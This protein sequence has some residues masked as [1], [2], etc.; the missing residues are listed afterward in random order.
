MVH[1]R[2]CGRNPAVVDCGCHRGPSGWVGH[3]VG[4][5][6]SHCRICRCKRSSIATWSCQAHG[7]CRCWV[8][9]Q[10]YRHRS[11]TVCIGFSVGWELQ[12]HDF[13]IAFPHFREGVL[14]G[15][16]RGVGNHGA[17]AGEARDS[18]SV[19]HDKCALGFPGDLRCLF[20]NGGLDK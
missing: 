16:L 12:V 17:L 20:E 2:R 10:S 4:D 15:W 3:C 13:R 8:W 5:P 9:V 7:W 6:A 11:N 18:I 1:L 19:R 14:W